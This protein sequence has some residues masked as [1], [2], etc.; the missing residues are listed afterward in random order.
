MIDSQTAN[1]KSQIA[2]L[3]FAVLSFGLLINS[4]SGK[5]AK[6][7]QYFAQGQ[8]LYE[9]NCSNCHQKNGKGLGLVYPPLASSDYLE[10]NFNASLCLMK[11]GI[12]GE[13]TVNGKNFNKPM[14]GVPSL[15]ELEIAE[16]TTYIS[17]SWGQQNGIVEISKVTSAL[18]E[19]LAQ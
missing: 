14:P 6:Y 17:N 8:V 1:H 2:L 19:C 7:Q 11:H 5:D 9:K 13:I 3:A 4:C 15:T 12:R 10:K 16:I 18:Q